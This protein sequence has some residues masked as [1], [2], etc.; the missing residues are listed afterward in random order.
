MEYIANCP[1]GHHTI[2]ETVKTIK[3]EPNERKPQREEKCVACGKVRRVTIIGEVEK[4]PNYAISATPEYAT[5]NR[6][7]FKLW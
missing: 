2:V 1:C 7:L 4:V 3:H 6:L 5:H